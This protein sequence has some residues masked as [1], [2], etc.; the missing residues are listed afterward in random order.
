MF[1]KVKLV[2]LSIALQHGSTLIIV[3][4]LIA[5]KSVVLAEV[6][7]EVAPGTATPLF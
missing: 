1:T 7:E 6:A 3:L 4:K 2:V 5:T